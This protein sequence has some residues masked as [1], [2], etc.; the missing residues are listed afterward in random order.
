MGKLYSSDV[1]KVWNLVMLYNK[2]LYNTPSQPIALMVK[3][4]ILIVSFCKF[5]IA[6]PWIAYQLYVVQIVFY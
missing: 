6:K 2:F 1:F 5:G 3:L 4:K